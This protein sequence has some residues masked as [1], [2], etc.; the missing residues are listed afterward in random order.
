MMSILTVAAS[1][2]L[3][4]TGTKL[5][6]KQNRPR[7]R[8]GKSLATQLIASPQ[9][10]TLKNGTVP[11]G[12][13]SADIVTRIVNELD[14]LLPLE[15]TEVIE[16]T[17][18]AAASKVDAGLNALQI[19]RQDRRG[20]HMQ[21]M[22]LDETTLSEEQIKANRHFKRSCIIFASAL[23]TLA[24]YP[25]LFVL[26]VPFFL[27]TGYPFYKRAFQ[28]LF[29]KRKISTYVV[30]ATISLGSLGSAAFLN[31]HFL[32]IGISSGLIRSYTFKI[33]AATKDNT[34]KS[35]TGLMGNQPQTVW[36]LR[37]GVEIEV[38]FE[39][40]QQGDILVIDA[41]QMIPVDGVTD[42]GMA[43][44]DQHMLTGEAQPAEKGVGDRVL[45][46]TIV[47]SGKLFIRVENTGEET[48]AAQI[49]QML[50][51]TAD[52]TSSIEL[53]GEEISDRAALPTL[54][55]SGVTLPIFG[56]AAA[57]TMLITGFGYNMK[58]LG[59]LSVLNYLQLTSL[60]GILIKDGR[61]LE[62][63]RNVDTVV[64]DK[65]G[66]LT[67]EQPHVGAIHPCHEY[68]LETILI[69]A[70]AAEHRQP[71]PIAR[72]ILQAAEDVGLALPTVSDAS[73]QVGYGIQVM[74]DGK[75]VRVGSNRF[76]AMESIEIPMEIANLAHDA[77][78]QGHSLVYVA[79][80]EQLAGVLELHPTVRP[81]A[82]R[83]VDVLHQRDI[84]IYIISGDNERPTRALANQLGIDHY[85]AE[86]LP[87]NKAQLISQLQE[88]GRF[89]CFVG[90]GINDSIALKTAQ[91]SVSLRGATTIAT[92]TAQII[93]MDETLNQLDRLFELAD[94]FEANMQTNLMTT[95]L[96]G[97]A[98]MG[99]VVL[100]IVGFGGAVALFWAGGIAGIL[101]AMRPLFQAKQIQHDET[102]LL[103]DAERA[104]ST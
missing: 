13:T 40:I 31:P 7:R 64:F 46:A 102:P 8:V 94:E 50:M 57:M 32:L 12:T 84:E 89:V 61:A 36:I 56:P 96:P 95:I 3:A 104:T 10:S 88:E 19:I 53:R 22:S 15:I 68:E 67:L 21:E 34:R 62:Q 63:I 54:L 81:E 73:Y 87:E 2:A 97:F 16:S 91:V 4:V 60:D 80:D 79:I 30:D 93:L 45:A 83:I 18:L 41:G 44:V 48:S 24:I 52:F 5:A 65:T 38:P 14:R 59:P 74:I 103:L 86:T 1:G 70:A 17:A 77:Q 100:G 9:S 66:T 82:K 49:G 39:T 47:L 98:I 26:H 23:T 20:Q 85:F 37:D 29:Q 55:L 43:S 42:Q 35:L 101:N 33:I 28:D 6:S 25:P 71:H 72:A 90:D 51:Q 99:G 11:N 27:Y 69:Y 76:M 78:G 58:L 75:L 92:D